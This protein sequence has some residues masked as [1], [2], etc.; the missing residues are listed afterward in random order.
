MSSNQ[1][2]VTSDL[3]I[4]VSTPQRF[5][6][7]FLEV[8]HEI[9]K[10]VPEWM[11]PLKFE[12]SQMLKAK[13]A[14][15]EHADARYFTARRNGRLVGRI[16][17]QIDTLVAKT[18]GRGTGQFGYFDC[19]DNQE[20]ANALFDAAESW[21]K[22]NGMTR[23][24]GPF[25]PS[26]NE[27][28]GMLIE[29][30]DTPNVMLMPHGR[31]Y[32][33]ALAEAQGYKK[34]KELYAYDYDV[35]PGL[36]P[37]F[38]KMVEWA[39]NNKDI[40]FRFISKKTRAD[41]IVLALKI[42]NE[43]WSGNWGFTP[44]TERE[45]ER[46][47]KSLALIL[48]PELGAFAYYKGEPVAF[49]IVLPDINQLTKDMNGSLLPFNWLKLLYRLKRRRFSRLRVPLLGTV[50][51]HQQ[52]R[53]GGIL[54][55]CLIEK[56]RQNTPIFGTTHAELSWI[57]EDNPGINNML[58]SIGGVIYKRYGVFEKELV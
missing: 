25:N 48:Q 28:V 1:I 50:K 45:G 51:E 24:I 18:M 31:P 2:D 15:C 16:S 7:D 58:S 49:M 53:I 32:Y 52:S 13:S 47:R 12:I 26:V 6:S 42:F 35:R 10:D 8:P 20:T 33:R 44:M 34:I 39:D 56:I 29:G 46:F 30:F 43:A 23:A 9:Y 54:S 37:K 21:L 41:D 36:E 5:N 3:R 11:P 22:D 4:E 55:M 40:S 17:A 27:E 14:Y 57:L 19:E 38:M